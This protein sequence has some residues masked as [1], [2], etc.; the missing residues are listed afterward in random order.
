MMFIYFI[1]YVVGSLLLILAILCLCWRWSIMRRSKA[2]TPEP[3]EM[4]TGYS[5]EPDVTHGPALGFV[6]DQPPRMNRLCSS[7]RMAQ[8]DDKGF[9]TQFGQEYQNLNVE[10][11]RNGQILAVE[12]QDCQSWNVE[13]IRNGPESP[14]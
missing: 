4:I 10:S 11:I 6:L 13:S 1:I 5:L 14:V 9:N 2:I 7:Y 12:S 3:T 8:T